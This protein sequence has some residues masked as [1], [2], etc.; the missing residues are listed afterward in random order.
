MVAGDSISHE[1]SGDHTWRWRLWQEFQRQR[2]Q[3]QF[4]GPRRGSYGPI[5]FFLVPLPADRHAALGG[6]RLSTQVSQIAGDVARHRPDLLLVMIGFNDLNHGAAPQRVVADMETYLNHVW[7]VNPRARVVLSRVM[8]S[9]YYPSASPRRL[10]IEAVNSGYIG[11]ANRFR[12]AGRSIVITSNAAR[13]APRLHTFDGLH[14]NPTGE[15]VIAQ[16][17]AATLHSMGVLPRVPAIARPYLAWSPNPQVRV[18]QR[19][20]RT[21]QFDWSYYQ[22]RLTMRQGILRIEGGR[23]KRPLV[24]RARYQASAHSR[25]LPRGRY[26]VRVAPVRMWMTGTYGPPVRFRVR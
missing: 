8:D 13:W 6:T 1:F 11:L 3:A 15:G 12:A 2:V 19:P 14:P 16:R 22:R 21:V 24:I 26:T 5:P 18:R 17:Y 9:L 7:E 4:V 20:R 23:L 25:R 10:P